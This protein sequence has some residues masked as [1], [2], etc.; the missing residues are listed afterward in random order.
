MSRGIAVYALVVPS[1]VIVLFSFQNLLEDTDL[2]NGDTV[3]VRKPDES[4]DPVGGMLTGEREIRWV[5]YHGLDCDPSAKMPRAEVVVGTDPPK[6]GLEGL[7][8]RDP[9]HFVAGGLSKQ[10]AE[11]ENIIPKGEEGAS[12]KKWLSEGV[13]VTYF[14]RPFKGYFW[15]E[16]L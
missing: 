16:I 1:L 13:K 12:V 14:F 8:F 4:F 7:V 9:N 5:N 3:W 6:F 2:R 15:R 10:M 11:W